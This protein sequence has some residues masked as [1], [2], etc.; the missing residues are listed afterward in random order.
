MKIAKILLMV[1]PTMLL[2][3]W[4]AFNQQP[5]VKQIGCS[6]LDKSQPS[7]FISYENVTR[8]KSEVRLK[9]HN[10]TTCSIVVETD[11]RAPVR[12][13]GR[14]GVGEGHAPK[15]PDNVWLPLHYLVQDGRGGKV[16]KRGFGW[17][18]SVF[19]YELSAGESAF[20][21]VPMIHFRKHFD[22][23]VP[24]NYAWEAHKS[25][26]MGVGGVIHRVYFLAE[27]LPALTGGNP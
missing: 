26:G 20:F 8:A 14:N 23:V 22:L 18:D 1:A 21:S 3:A 25:V 10:N 15:F 19:T 7:Q 13:L 4:P 11:D 6:L 12:V 27:D 2:L 5:P 9:L 17:G 24:F 16:P